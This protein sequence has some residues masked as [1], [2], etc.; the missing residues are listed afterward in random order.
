[1]S[2]HRCVLCP[3]EV[4]VILL[5]RANTPFIGPPGF[6]ADV[7]FQSVVAFP[8]ALLMQLFMK[9]SYKNCCTKPVHPNH[10]FESSMAWGR[11]ASDHNYQFQPSPQHYKSE[12]RNLTELVGMTPCHPTM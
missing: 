9:L 2:K 10:A 4:V 8:V 11:A 6:S 12:I 7:N 1:M 5:V 3:G